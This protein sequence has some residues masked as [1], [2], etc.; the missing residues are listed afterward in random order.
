MRGGC[1]SVQH[2]TSINGSKRPEVLTFLL[3][4]MLLVALY[5]R[6]ES[7]GRNEEKN[8]YCTPL[9]AENSCLSIINLKITFY[10]LTAALCHTQSLLLGPQNDNLR[11]G[12]YECVHISEN[13]GKLRQYFINLAKC[14]E[15]VA[16]SVSS[17]LWMVA[18]FTNI[19]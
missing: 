1:S 18:L 14:V 7:Q 15:S 19:C 17:S 9:F 10:F 4:C 5:N 13:M 3:I 16:I 8:F 6:G 2:L 11:C 12:I